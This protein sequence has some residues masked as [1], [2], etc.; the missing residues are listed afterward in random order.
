MPYSKRKNGDK[1][2]VINSDTGDVK[3]TH[4]TE[5]DA[6]DQL[7]A[8]YIH[9]DDESKV[10][11][12][13]V[14]IP[15][16]KINQERHEVY[17]WAAVEEPDNSDEIMDYATSKPLFQD[18]SNRAQ[19]RSGGKSLGNLRSMHSNIAA[20]KF[21]EMRPDD[22]VKGFYVGAQVIDDNEWKK[23]EKGV[24]TGFSIGGNYVNR[25]S[26]YKNPGKIRYTAKPTE[27][28]LVDSPCISSATFEVVKADGMIVKS[29]F[30][31]GN[32][33]NL[34]KL[35]GTTDM[36]SDEQRMFL[37]TKLADAFPVEETAEDMVPP[38]ITGPKYW[39][40]DFSRDCVYVCHNEKTYKIP[41]MVDENNNVTFGEQ[42]EVIRRTIY[43]PVT[44]GKEDSVDDLKKSDIPG[45]PEP[46]ADIP[47]SSEVG[48]GFTVEHMPTPNATM[49]LQPNSMPVQEVIA[50]HTVASKDLDAAMEAWLPKIGQM[51]ESSV[52][53]QFAAAD[54]VKSTSTAPA[55]KIPVYRK[56]IKVRKEN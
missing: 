2:E 38:P 10:T 12:M 42:T 1:W 37:Q 48:P 51:V 54:L 32:T 49:E 7:A 3:G 5:E 47:L 17:G 27:I 31:P 22:L 44:M 23:V 18:W 19:K 35:D 39:L 34:L 26:D 41:Y 15:I 45:S 33:G 11:K 16:R 40:Y 14:F 46:I 56:P 13:D 29:E 43:E 24:Y 4:D 25:W 50:G 21:I 53:K 30:H 20:G 52:A 9:A 55:L 28:S 6:N 36:T 8:L